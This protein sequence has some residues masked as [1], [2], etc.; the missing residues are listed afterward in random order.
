MGL[1]GIA[2][3]QKDVIVV[4][5]SNTFDP[6]T[7]AGSYLQ[8]VAK[9][10][11][12]QNPDIEV[13]MNWGSWGDLWS[14][15]G[16][17]LSNRQGPD[18]VVGPRD[19]L[20]ASGRGAGQWE[21]I[22]VVPEDKFLS[23][24]QKQ[25][26]G[27]AVLEAS[28][29]P[30]R[31]GY[32]VWPWTLY[33]DGT[34]VVNGTMLREAGYDA[35]DIQANGWAM[36]KFVEISRAVTKDINGDGKVDQW[37]AY[38]GPVTGGHNGERIANTGLFTHNIPFRLRSQGFL[39]ATFVDIK[40][41][42]LH[43]DEEGFL[44]GWKLVREMVD[45][46]LIP[47]QSVGVS[48][49]ESREAFIN[50]ITAFS[51]DGP[52]LL[53]L[54]A[55]RNTRVSRGLE[56]GEVFEPVVVPRPY[57]AGNDWTKFPITVLA[58]GFYS[59]KQEPYKGDQHTENVFKFAKFLSNPVFQVTLAHRDSIPPDMRVYY[60][61]HAWFPGIL[62]EDRNAQYMETIAQVWQPQMGIYIQMATTE[63]MQKALQKYDTEIVRPTREAVFLGAITPE[64]GIAKLKAELEKIGR[65]IP[66]EQ[67]LTEGAPAI[68]KDMD[69]YAKSIGQKY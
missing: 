43:L 39:T 26:L 62:G 2:S 32:M 67:R 22:L 42:D 21:D 5:G 35:Y 7:P 55:E 13:Q 60:G 29:F 51:F 69:D 18:I 25:A 19:Y 37:A 34:M 65:E 63:A 53:R 24:L 27:P 45:D 48:M 16:I 68:A 3:A 12:E 9:L 23:P 38:F 33:V 20:M 30:G 11:M 54:V 47:A 56:P 15:V 28:R 61:D 6:S 41:G 66:K 4:M 64:E 31:D 14:K 8:E 58:H 50:N 36:D 40:T 44:T 49:D 52:D 59:F 10:F 57:F 17:M 1:A 46:G